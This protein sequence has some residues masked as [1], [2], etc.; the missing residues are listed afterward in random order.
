MPWPWYVPDRREVK[1]VNNNLHKVKT[2]YQH[3]PAEGI[4]IRDQSVMER[5]DGAKLGREFLANSSGS[6]VRRRYKTR[7]L[8]TGESHVVG[9]RSTS[10]QFP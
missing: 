7:V 4:H 3:N 5:H 1:C 6:S 9:V 10:H 2:K 8:V